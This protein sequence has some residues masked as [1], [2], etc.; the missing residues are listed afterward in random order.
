MSQIPPP[1][2][3]FL[4]VAPYAKFEIVGDGFIDVLRIQ[5]FRGTLDAYCLDCDRD[6]V[7]ESEPPCLV[8][9]RP[10]PRTAGQ[11]LPI[12]VDDL[13]G[14]TQKAYWPFDLLPK[15]VGV[16]GPYTL[17]ELEPF[18][19]ADRVFQIA[20]KCT[21]NFAHM[22][23]FVFRV[24][25]KSIS[26]IGQSPSLADLQSNDLQ[27]Y[28]KVLGNEKYRELTRAVGLHAHGVG[29]GAIVYLRRILE[30]L[31]GV[32]Q[33]RAAKQEGWDNDAFVRAR[34]D[35]R[36]QLLEHELPSFL[37][38]NRRIYGIL[39]LG[40]HEL[41]EQK[42]LE[43]FEPIKVG[44]ELILDEQ[45]ERQQREAKMARTAIAIGKL[46]LRAE[47]SIKGQRS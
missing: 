1:A 30:E 8:A 9:A 31:I 18:A 17:T 4:E 14:D 34:M 38:Q 42:C 2:Q 12:S 28:R 27:I 11:N 46:K 37:V 25:D 22:H 43:I 13:I 33:E 7:F 36:I 6:S 29:I 24:C 44:I 5:Y 20:F 39:S 45:L 21:R 32:A 3:F 41:D 23:Y 15:G 35:E 47:D 26:K 16:N 40:I 10:G 19:L